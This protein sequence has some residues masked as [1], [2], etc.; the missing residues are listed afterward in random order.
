MG[1]IER[2][3]CPGFALEARKALRVRREGVR[4]NLDRDLATQRGIS[5]APD[6]AIPPS[7]I[8]S[9]TLYTPRRRPG[10]RAKRWG[11]YVNTPE[12]RGPA[13]KT[14]SCGSAIASPQTAR[15]VREYQPAGVVVTKQASTTEASPRQL[16]LR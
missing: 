9:V 8:G 7:P 10:V 13:F 3:E 4:Q 14:S 16:P 2:R 15:R 11:L 1:M 6:M 12:V 5:R